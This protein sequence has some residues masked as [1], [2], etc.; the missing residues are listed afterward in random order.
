MNQPWYR[1]LFGRTPA[2]DPQS[3]QA[4]LNHGDSQVQFGLGL[5]CA[6]G[7]GGAQDYVQAAEWYRTAAA[8]SHALAQ[9]NLGLMYASGQ[10]VPQDDTAAVMWIRKAADQGDA[11]AQFNLGVRHQRTGADTLHQDALESR[12]EA[13]KW[14]NLAAAQGYRGSAAACER[15]TLTMT[16]ESVSDG[17][18]R[19]AAFVAEMAKRPQNQ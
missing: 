14:L 13:Y 6:S 16:R 7:E 18:Q 17:N 12:I 2:S 8:Q 15:V 9:C 11:A 10:G 5:L 4:A 19:I 3:T 1:R